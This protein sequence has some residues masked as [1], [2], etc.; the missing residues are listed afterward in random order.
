ML[1]ETQF[2]L[3]LFI[4]VS[5][6]HLWGVVTHQD[7]LSF[8]SK[9]FL[10]STL[11]LYFFLSTRRSGSHFRRGILLGLLFSIFGDTFLL[12]EGSTYFL[13]GLGA[14]LIAQISYLSAFLSL[15]PL[16]QGSLSRRPWLALPFL[17]YL[18]WLLLY[19][20]SD[21]PGAFRWPVTIYGVVITSMAL[22]SVN[23]YKKLPQPLFWRLLTGV[24]FF[25]AS[26]SLIALSRFKSEGLTLA[27]PGLW[28]MVTYLV[29][30]YLIAT[31]G[32]GVEK[33]RGNQAYS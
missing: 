21:L 32:V 10:L 11:S 26:D 18:A 23:L 27:E 20:W 2:F 16:K 17:A 3:Y 9:P 5:A 31:S 19:L 24:L 1:R 13:L 4:L 8:Y 22:G 25:L 6:V 12:F 7:A 14:F 33:L 29:A 28:I 15:Q 30:Q